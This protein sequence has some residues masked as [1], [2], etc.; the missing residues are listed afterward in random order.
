[1]CCEKLKTY[2]LYPPAWT[3]PLGGALYLGFRVL[4]K[5]TGASFLRESR[6]EG[7]SSGRK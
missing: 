1:M 2:L 7:A 6:T 5:V 4:E 3:L